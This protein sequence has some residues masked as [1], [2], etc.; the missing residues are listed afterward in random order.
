MEYIV[1]DQSIVF[2]IR[3]WLSTEYSE[4]LNNYIDKNIK[5]INY[6]IKNNKPI[7]LTR[8]IYLL[9]DD[10]VKKYP[11]SNLSFM[12]NNWDSVLNQE[13]KNIKDN[14]I[15][16][17]HLLKYNLSF[18]SCV[19]NK[20]KNGKEFIAPHSDEEASGPMNAVISISLG[21]SRT[22][23]LKEK[24]TSKL[25]KVQLNNGDCLVMLGETQKYWNHSIPSDKSNGMRIS[26]TYRFINV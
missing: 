11:Y 19:I 23:W 15:T 12:V 7:L 26:L 1:N 3:N 2:V 14:L 20:Y 21:A 18:N 8:S 25:L 13:I 16:D 10:T 22:L 24:S 9:G 5:W 6:G 17:E 4:Q